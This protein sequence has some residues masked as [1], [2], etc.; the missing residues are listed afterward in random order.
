MLSDDPR[1][2]DIEE[3]NRRFEEAKTHIHKGPWS[4]FMCIYWGICEWNLK[5]KKE[6]V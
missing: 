2:K 3:V 1:P 4:T 6:Y 5:R